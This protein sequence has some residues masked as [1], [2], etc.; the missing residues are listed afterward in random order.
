MKNT[1]DINDKLTTETKQSTTGTIFMRNITTIDSGAFDPVD[2]IIGFSWHVDIEVSGE[3]D[4]NHMVH[5]FSLVKKTARQLLL[6]TI[7]HA[8]IIPVGS[9]SVSLQITDSGTEAWIL[10]SSKEN[11][12]STNWSYNCPK[13]ATFPIKSK[14]LST[15]IICAELNRKLADLLPETISSL[16]INLREEVL[17]PAQAVFRYTHGISSHSGYCQRLFH[18]HRSCLEVY[19]NDVRQPDLEHYAVSEILGKNVH[20]ASL[21]QIKSTGL[22]AGT[23]AD[24]PELIEIKYTSSDGEFSGNIPANRL[25]IVEGETSIENLSQM[26]AKVIRRKIGYSSDKIK[27]IAYEGIGKGAVSEA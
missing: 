11:D 12:D 2:G 14:T 10:S 22:E 17:N 24:S 15:E 8:L 25:F 5:D 13:G 16:S 26:L 21:E 20:I 1:K 18:G 23:R 3:L 7:D 19:I 27:V 4:E 6:D 9:E